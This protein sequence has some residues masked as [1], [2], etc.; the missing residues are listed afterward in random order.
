M[1]IFINSQSIQMTAKGSAQR[2]GRDAQFRQRII[3]KAK[4]L[5]ASRPD[6]SYVVIFGAVERYEVQVDKIER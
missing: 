1:A 3:I 4:A 6:I 5:L 2:Y